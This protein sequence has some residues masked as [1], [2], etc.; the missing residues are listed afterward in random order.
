MTSI[1]TL[2]PDIMK[3]VDE[4]VDQVDEAAI[5]QLLSDI[6]YGVR[7]QLTKSERQ[8]SGTLRMSNVGKPDC[9]LWHEC[10]DTP[11][12]ELRPETRIKFLYGDIVEALVLFLANAAGHD[13]KH[14][15]KEV[16][17]NGVKGHIDAEIDG[18]LIDVK[19]AS[20]FGFNKF[21]DGTLPE[22][23]LFGYMGQLSSY[24][25]AGGWDRAAFLAFN[26]E[27][28]AMCLYEPDEID[29]DHNADQRIDF[30]KGMVTGPQPERSFDAIPDGKS[31]NMKLGTRCA[32]C[33]FKDECW[34]DSNDGQGLRTFIYSN[35]P[36]FLT[37]V[38]REP[39]VP[40]AT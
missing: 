3:M 8:R 23:D 31:G 39:D 15:Q 19:S 27:S 2:V 21:K 22:D 13:V 17:L 34:K 18:V 12:E 35:G 37:H 14:E 10:N 28:G 9:Q 11:S 40:E 30:V 25:Q 20:K 16:E 7:R 33:A 32:Y 24:K 6:E 29:M 1:D 4:G 36:R 38:E 5:H 26:K